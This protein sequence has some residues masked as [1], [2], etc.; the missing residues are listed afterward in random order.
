MNAELNIVTQ[1]LMQ[2]WLRTKALVR[3]DQFE[4]SV[5]G[6]L[7]DDL[8]LERTDEIS[9]MDKLVRAKILTYKEFA[10]HV[11][12]TKY[13]DKE[14]LEDLCKEVRD[15]AHKRANPHSHTMAEAVEAAYNE[16]RETAKA[17]GKDIP[18]FKEVLES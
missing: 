14:G 18:E 16:V 4:N 13:I 7:L 17:N 10:A 5:L 2:P 15:A 11:D 12:N 1:L 3:K 8:K 6:E 9:I